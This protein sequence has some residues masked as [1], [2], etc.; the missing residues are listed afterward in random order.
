MAKNNQNVDVNA[1]AA[2]EAKTEKTKSKKDERVQIMIPYIEGE[3]PEVTV[4]INGHITKFKKGEV[5]SV[6]ANVAK[7]LQRSNKNMKNAIKNQQKFKKQVMD[8]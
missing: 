8:L 1:E 4:I 5:V 6:P 3:D 7:V 2:A